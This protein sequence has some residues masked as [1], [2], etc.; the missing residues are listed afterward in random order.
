VSWACKG[1]DFVCLQ[2]KADSEVCSIC[3]DRQLE[4][5]IVSEHGRCGHALCVRCAHQLCGR[6][7]V[8]PTCPFCRGDIASFEALLSAG[9]WT[10]V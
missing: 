6:G 5:A 10:M 3:F 9:V 4:V 1:S 2:A 8:V 7:L